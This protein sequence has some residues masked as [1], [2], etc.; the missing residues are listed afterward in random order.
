M[1]RSMIV[2]PRGGLSVDDAGV[3]APPARPP[4][5]LIHGAAG[6]A[7]HWLPVAERLRRHGRV[8]V[9]ELPGHGFSE[10]PRDID[11]STEAFAEA[12]HLVVE[13][14]RI[15]RFVLA[16]HSLA[17]DV[18]A[19]YAATHPQR[20]VALAL[21]D[22]GPRHRTAAELEDLRRGFRPESY[23][24]FTTRW[25]EQILAHARPATRET[26]LRGLRAMPRENFM[27][28]VFG[29]LG[30]DQRAAV[31]RYPGPKL[32][33]CA[34]AFGIA[35]RWKGAAVEVRT[36][37]GVSHWLH[38]DDPDTIADALDEWVKRVVR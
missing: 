2:G 36:F 37:P 3:S 27:A 9:P 18:V 33:L 20:V 16:G 31:E 11:W 38:L 34:E 23:E 8:L 15:D 7:A 21:V 4:I 19:Q 25:F 13:E 35:D 24:A 28:L 12:L 32:V 10:P 29:S 6:S 1:T 22:T 30:F 17:G 14:R 5:V 26:V